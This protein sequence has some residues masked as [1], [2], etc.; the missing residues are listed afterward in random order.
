MNVPLKQSKGSKMIIRL[1]YRLKH[2]VKLGMM[3]K[4]NATLLIFWQ[5]YTLKK[6]KCWLVRNQNHF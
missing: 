6:L 2:L 4:I 1:K 5:L 3:D